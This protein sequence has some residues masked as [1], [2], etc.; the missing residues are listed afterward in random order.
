VTFAARLV[1]G[2]TDEALARAATRTPTR[3]RTAIKLI[4][5]VG[6]TEIQER[7]HTGWSGALKRGYGTDIH[8][9]GTRTV[10]TINNPALYHDTAEEGR[11]PGKQPPVAALILWVGSVLG[12][13]P[14]PE[15]EQ[16]AFL[17]AREIGARGYPGHHM[18]EQGMTA[19]RRQMGP[20][21]SKMGLALAKDIHP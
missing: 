15:R 12:I 10:G 21:L 3:I 4:V 2:T 13:P 9:T 1:P 6:Q 14:G 18:V 5:T 20:I 8:S 16:V 11:R 17:V 19:T 7:T